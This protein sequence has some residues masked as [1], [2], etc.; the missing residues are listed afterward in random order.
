[1]RNADGA[2]QVDI[3]DLLH[4]IGYMFTGGSPPA[5]GQWLCAN[6]IRLKPACTRL[7]SEPT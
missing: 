6:A 1:M 2:K 5:A 7:I 3:S 4:L